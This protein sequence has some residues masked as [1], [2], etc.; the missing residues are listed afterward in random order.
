VSI[1]QPAAPHA[2]AERYVPNTTRARMEL[3]V[4][5]TVGLDEAIRRTLAWHRRPNHSFNV[6]N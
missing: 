1:A 5:S 6:V 2:A 4:S 3:G